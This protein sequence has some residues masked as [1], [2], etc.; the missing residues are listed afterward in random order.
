MAATAKPKLLDA[1]ALL[2]ADH[3]N[4]EMLFEELE[5]TRKDERKVKLAQEI[6]TELSVHALAEEK[7]FYPAL[8]NAFDKKDTKL[9]DEAEVEHETLKELI[10][11]V[12]GCSPEDK[13]FDAYLTV[14]KEYVAHHVKE[15]EGEMM[16]KAKDTDLDLKALGQ[17]IVEFKATLQ[18]ALDKAS[19][20][21]ASAE[22]EVPRL[23]A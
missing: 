16:P 22:V 21:P 20:A 14:L 1:I 10:A 13:L 11:K 18:P 17:E 9:L 12:N 5:K 2:K 6:C 19:A 3:R 8:Y 7:V 15:E 23:A 4:V